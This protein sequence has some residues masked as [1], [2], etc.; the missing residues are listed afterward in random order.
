MFIPDEFKFPTILNTIRKS[1]GGYIFKNG[2]LL[3]D[4][5]GFAKEDVTIDLENNIMHIY[6][7][8]EILGEKYELDKKFTIPSY[9]LNT[10]EPIK[11][12]VENG[13]IHIE[14]TKGEKNNK[15]KV[16]IS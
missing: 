14:L 7:E 5:P 12:K 4:A 10:D 1:V 15:P 16:V 11:A 8:K 13:L 6:G 2:V 3:L 9:Y